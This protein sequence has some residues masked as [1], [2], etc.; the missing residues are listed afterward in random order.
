MLKVYLKGF[1]RPI[2]VIGNL[3]FEDEKYLVLKHIDIKRKILWENVLYIEDVGFF[4]S[5]PV[6]KQSAPVP[7][8]EQKDRTLQD[9]ISDAVK[10]K[11]DLQKQGVREPKS[12][13]PAGPGFQDNITNAIGMQAVTQREPEQQVHYDKT[14]LTDINIFLTG[15]KQETLSVK[16]PKG[17]LTGGY[18]PALAQEIFGQD[19]V[20][21]VMGDFV[22]SGVPRVDG[23]NVYFETRSTADVKEKL[24]TAGSMLTTTLNA[25]QNMAQKPKPSLALDENFSI[26]GSPFQKTAHFSA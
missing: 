21:S 10:R 13:Q 3:L 4:E 17:V 26:P 2:S 25:G 20:K 5:D 6:D 18:N 15:H 12:G 11:V 7:S 23:N 19:I 24:N 16:V 9:L 1:D 8:T 14:D 22:I